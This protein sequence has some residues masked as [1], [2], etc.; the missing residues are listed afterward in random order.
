MKSIHATVLVTLFLA[1]AAAPA[2]PSSSAAPA[3][4]SSAADPAFDAELMS[5]QQAWAKANYDLPQ[6]GGRTEAFSLCARKARRKFHQAAS[7]PPRG[8]DLGRHH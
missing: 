8:V 3:A 6:G 2:A 4:P 1:S 5:L 7:E